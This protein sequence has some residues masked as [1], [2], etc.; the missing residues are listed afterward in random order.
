MSYEVFGDGLYVADHVLGAGRLRIGTSEAE[1]SLDRPKRTWTWKTRALV[2]GM[3]AAVAAVL[4][5]G[6]AR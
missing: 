4:V 5:Q 2:G 1:W 6:V 3:F